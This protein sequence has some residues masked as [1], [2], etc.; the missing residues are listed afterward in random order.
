MKRL[1]AVGLILS[2]A[3]MI[4]W[5]GFSY[6][7][8]PPLPFEI[9][10]APAPAD[11]LPDF[12]GMGL[13]ASR[14]ERLEVLTPD[15]KSPVATAIAAPDAEGRKSPL[16]WRNA[17]TEPV[18]FADI[19]PAELAK[20]IAAIRQHAPQDA[21]VLAWWDLSRQIRSFA[22]RQA[23]LDDPVARGLLTP[24]AWSA[25]A[26]EI[27]AKQREFWAAGV[28][29]SEGAAF[30]KFVDALLSDE[31]RGA[32]A[33]AE[34]AGGKRAFIAVR[35][36]DVWK[37]AAARPDLLSIAYRDFASAG[38]QHGLM[39]ATRKWLEEQ[40]IEGGFAVEPM[41][42]P[43]RL[44]YLPRKSDSEKLLVRMLPFSTSNPMALE[45]LQ[46]VYQYKG[47]WIYE[48]NAAKN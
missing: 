5:A 37:A 22:G 19:A 17:M 42:G 12:A 20:V 32:A 15:A 10:A 16:S 21:V 26:K 36:S 47:Y 33:L 6:L 3:A 24:S 4:A 31:A 38:D 7:R 23:P 39:K 13:D 30:A 2:G 25:R 28:P 46:L 29:A 48:L 1:I 44:H 8:P 43:V 18:F 40:K 34:L 27:D 35:L 41:G 9:V 45:R 14:T 11:A